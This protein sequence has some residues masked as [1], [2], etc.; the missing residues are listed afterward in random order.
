M[1]KKKVETKEAVTM[2][3]N[4][5]KISGVVMAMDKMYGAGMF[6]TGDNIPKIYKI[7]FGEPMLDYVYTGGTPI[8]RFTELLGEPHAGKTRNGLKAMASF[9]KYCFN[10]HTPFALTAKWEMKN[11][12]PSLKSCK[13]SSCD[14]PTTKIQAMVDVEGT[15]DPDFLAKMG[16]DTN[17]V[18]YIRPD[19]PSHTVDIIDTFLR[20]PNIGLILLDSIGS[21]GSD[22]E[23]DE[24]M[25]DNKMN[26]N[27]VFFNR[28][29]RKWQMALNKNTNE[30]GMENGTTMIVVNQSYQTLSMYSTEV[31]QG[32]RGLRH[33]KAMSIKHSIGEKNKDANTKEIYGVHIRCTNEKNK[34]GM[35]YRRGEYYLN[36]DPNDPYLDYCATNINLQYVELAIKFNVI[37]Q[38]GGWFYYGDEKWQGKAN[39]IDGVTPE[40]RAEVDAKIYTL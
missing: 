34:T 13:C 33:G 22:R 12:Q 39:L 35:P 38:R 37:E 7:P 40:I 26:Q 24:K 29:L 19:R 5:D 11:G 4:F 32:G 15:S 3:N 30:T 20:Q 16:V 36:L 14:E 27:P 23:V 1:A 10:C 25:E 28:A 21:M 31:A 6:K 18:I 8:G 9:Q 17:G 2:Q